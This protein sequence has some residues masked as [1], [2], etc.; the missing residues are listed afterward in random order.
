MRESV[1]NAL[2]VMAVAVQLV[3]GIGITTALAVIA[4]NGFGVPGATF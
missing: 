4:L 3:A 2:F 1:F